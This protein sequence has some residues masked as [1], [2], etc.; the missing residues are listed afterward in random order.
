MTHQV[1]AARLRRRA[2]RRCLVAVHP[3]RRAEPPRLLADPSARRPDLAPP[4]SELSSRPPLAARRLRADSGGA[5]RLGRR[6]DSGR[7][8]DS[9][10]AVAAARGRACLPRARRCLRRGRVRATRAQGRLRDERGCAR[11]RA[12]CLPGR[13]GKAR[14]IWLAA[15]RRAPLASA[16]DPSHAHHQ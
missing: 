5:S 12:S 8:A 7:A 13:D 4:R 10:R 3:T 16:H 15:L 9:R 1:I 14:F 2:F 11:P 6:L